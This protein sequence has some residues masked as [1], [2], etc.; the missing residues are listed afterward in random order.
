VLSRRFGV[1]EAEQR[2]IIELQDE[3]YTRIWQE[4]GRLLDGARESLE[5]VRRLGVG[6]GLA[7]SSSRNEVE[8]FLDRFEL[9]DCFDVTLSLDD[10]TRA[11]PDP[12]IYVSAAR[13]LDVPAGEMLVVED[14][15]HGVRAAKSAGAICVVVRSPHVPPERVEM[16]DLQI[17]SIRELPP[18]LGR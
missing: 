5:A 6:V 14:S 3:F 1:S 10:V 4:Q 17:R 16:A 2:R 18:L 8:A 11:K 13:R 12:E 7:T 15:E 9:R